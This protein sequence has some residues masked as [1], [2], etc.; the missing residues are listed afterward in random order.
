[1]LEKGAEIEL[2]IQA[3][4]E[5]GRG[6]ARVDGFVVFVRQAIPGDRVLARVV[7]SRKNYAEAVLL[8][9]LA[10]SPQRVEPRCRYFGAC[11]GCNWQHFSYDAQLEMKHRWVVDA[12]RHIGGFSSIDVKPA[13]GSSD[14]YFYRNKME[15]SFSDRRWL[16]A[17]E[18]ASGEKLE[19]EF[20]LGLHVADRYDK[21]LDIRECWLQSELSNR[22]LN[23]VRL[24]AVEN[25]VPVY[26]ADR[27]GGYLRFLVIRQ[28]RA[29]GE[30]LVNL[31]T[32]DDR[33]EVAQSLSDFL[34]KKVGGITTFVNTVN[35]RKAQIA[36]G[37]EQRVHSGQGTITELLGGLTFRVSANSFFQT[38]TVQ[39][40]R[41]CLTVQD[42]AGLKSDD[43][44]YDLYSGTGALALFISPAVARVVGI[45]VVS[46]SVE[47]A[48]W[49]A[50]AN[51][52][53]N[54]VFVEGDVKETLIDDGSVREKLGD[55]SVIILD[56][57][58]SGLH[59]KLAQALART[60]PD[61]IVY[62]SCNPPTQAR[63]IKILSEGGYS[64]DVLQPLD[65][66]P[67]TDHV[68]CIA[69]LTRRH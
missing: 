32:F 43:I 53:D 64:V 16:T 47:D 38:N 49:N 15:F 65:M 41:M 7:K 27:E 59:P 68:E 8:K 14:V 52:V 11:G 34:E 9:V 12:F 19:K 61:R 29:T 63:D 45:E 1:M 39:A 4:A 30:V 10:P 58:R 36:Y 26:R 18:I 20:A 55:P 44:V 17:Q 23:A 67:H 60:G 31:V 69:R 35:R 54:C 48:R 50:T 22:I 51:G 5:K 40:E 37:E 66:F 6:V 3:G 57:P 24:W 46:R 33:S 21:V 2:D 25:G 42:F 56:P 62:V 28:S 13:F